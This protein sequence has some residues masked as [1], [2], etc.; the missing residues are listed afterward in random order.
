M[1]KQNAFLNQVWNALDYA[2]KEPWFKG[3]TNGNKE[4]TA[5]GCSDK[6]AFI[7]FDGEERYFTVAKLTHEITKNDPTVVELENVTADLYCEYAGINRFKYNTRYLMF[8]QKIGNKELYWLL[9][10]L[11]DIEAA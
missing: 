8:S 9:T 4:L 2:E 10:E 1:K 7:K 11:K 6:L 5:L 3:F